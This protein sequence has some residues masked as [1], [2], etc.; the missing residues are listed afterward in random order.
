MLYS[1]NQTNSSFLHNI[2]D[3]LQPPIGQCLFKHQRLIRL[4]KYPS[5][6]FIPGLFICLP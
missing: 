2:H 1:F 4:D 5:G 3:I 6:L